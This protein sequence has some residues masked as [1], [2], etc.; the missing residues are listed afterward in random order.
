MGL[1]VI[2][3]TE[4]PQPVLDTSDAREIWMWRL[5]R[6]RIGSSQV[7]KNSQ[8]A[9]SSRK[10]LSK[11]IGLEVLIQIDKAVLITLVNNIAPGIARD[12]ETHFPTNRCNTGRVIV[13]CFKIVFIKSMNLF[14]FS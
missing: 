6:H 14:R 13:R 4:P 2:D 3:M 11:E 1:T 9:I 8:Y 7:S 12:N 10:C 5:S